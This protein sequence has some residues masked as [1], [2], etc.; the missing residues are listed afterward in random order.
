MRK[1][2]SVALVAA[3]SMSLVGCGGSSNTAATTAAA[4][5]ETGAAQ[6][7]AAP[8]AAKTYRDHLTVALGSQFTQLDPQGNGNANEVHAQLF[9]MTHDVLFNYNPE[10]Q[11]LEP[12]LAK[13][14][15]WV[16]EACTKL[17]VVLRDD[18]SFHNGTKLTAEDVQFT[19]DRCPDT[20]V[21]NYYDHCEIASDTELT[22]VLKSGNVDFTYVLSR[23]FDAIVSKAAVE[24][25]ADWGAMIGSG[26][27]KFDKAGYVAGDTVELDRNDAYW[28]DLPETKEITIKTIANAS[29]RLMALESDEV[30]IIRELAN[31]EIDIAKQNKKVEV[32]EYP[33]TRLYYFA[34]NTS[35][36]PAT[37]VNLRKA[38]SYAINKED[39]IAAVGDAGA[40]VAVTF[41]GN[42][43][44]YYT[45]DLTDPVVYD[46]EK[47]KEFVA[48][49][50]DNTSLKLMANTTNVQFKTLAQVI[51]EQLR[52]VGITMEIEEVDSA[53][54]SANTKYNSNTHESMIYSIGTNIWDSDMAR[55]LAVDTNSNKAIVNDARITE[56]LTEGSACVDFDARAAYYEEIQEINNAQ[57]YYIPLYYCSTTIAHTAGMEGITITP[58][59]YYDF[60]QIELAE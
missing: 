19:L 13:E 53:G 20:Q 21:T 23:P 2:L 37:D 12:E 57:C 5:K 48:L 49:C 33:T 43:M 8:E 38:V 29:S 6:E 31:T 52:Q 44:N 60:S 24:A 7:A 59:G 18:V 30:Q 54:I 26:A 39:L 1:I 45:E 22:I 9:A 32:I 14:W 41:Y 55:L 47:A 58:T 42:S 34:F 56:L 3:M 11:E 35:N 46:P 4:A 15:N 27:W 17:H 10:T 40:D 28:G 16:D 36:G 50:G 51:Q 25:D